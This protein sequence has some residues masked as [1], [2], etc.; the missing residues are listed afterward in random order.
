[1]LNEV[2][3][4]FKTNSKYFNQLSLKKSL[5]NLGLT[6]LIKYAVYKICREHLVSF[7]DSL[8]SAQAC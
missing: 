7:R 6:A 4:R 3:K 1:M 8:L 2:E 5:L